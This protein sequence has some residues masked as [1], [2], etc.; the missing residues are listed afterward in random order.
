MIT[1]NDCTREIVK[2]GINN[3]EVKYFLYKADAKTKVYV[4][5]L[6]ESYGQDRINTEKTST[7]A[8]YNLWNTASVDE[9]EKRKTA[10]QEKLTLITEVEN[11]MNEIGST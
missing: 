3:V 10:A 7:Q 6:T 11:K 1:K 2:V 8:E 5:T 4:D 9:V